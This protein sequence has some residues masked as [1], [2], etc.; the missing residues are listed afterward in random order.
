MSLKLKYELS[1]CFPKSINIELLMMNIIYSFLYYGYEKPEIEFSPHYILSD[2]FDEPL[3]EETQAII[4]FNTIEEE[5]LKRMLRFLKPVSAYII[6]PARGFNFG[7]SKLKKAIREELGNQSDIILQLPDGTELG[8]WMI[9]ILKN[10]IKRKGE[11]N[12]E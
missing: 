7:A 3:T 5:H 11:M 4:K 8:N 12:Y 2:S 10:E 6:E 1:L 9:D